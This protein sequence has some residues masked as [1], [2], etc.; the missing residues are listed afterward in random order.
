[1]V[2]AEPDLFGVL[3]AEKFSMA[4]RKLSNLK[5]EPQTNPSYNQ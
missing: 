3:S 4:M 1:M 2:V 5:T